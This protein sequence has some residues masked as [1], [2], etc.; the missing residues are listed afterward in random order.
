MR[1]YVFVSFYCV[2]IQSGIQAGHLAHE[3]VYDYIS[4]GGSCEASK[5]RDWAENHKTMIVLGSGEHTDQLELADKLEQLGSVLSLPTSRFY[6]PGLNNTLTATGII[7]PE[8]IYNYKEEVSD[9]LLTSFER[10]L[11][12]LI[13]SYPLAK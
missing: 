11:F 8:H 7:V 4:V 3:L 10:D 6:E 9:Y 2:G 5:T 1:L 13:K 12:T